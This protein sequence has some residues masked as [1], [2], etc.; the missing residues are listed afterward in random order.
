MQSFLKAFETDNAADATHLSLVGG[1]YKIQEPDVPRFQEMYAQHYKS[2]YLVEKVKYPSYFYMDIDKADKSLLTNIIKR[3]KDIKLDCVV[4]I[5]NADENGH[6]D[7]RNRI[8]CGAQ[9]G[10]RTRRASVATA[11]ANTGTRVCTTRVCAWSDPTR[12]NAP[13]ASIIPIITLAV[14]ARS[15]R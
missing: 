14:T 7:A 6:F 15:R 4:A 1:K 12:R 13:N 2:C 10:R 5:R 9:Q 8:E 11:S 3:L